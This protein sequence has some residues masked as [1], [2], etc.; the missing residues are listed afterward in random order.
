MGQLNK[1]ACAPRR[2]P[3]LTERARPA[4]SRS[5][6]SHQVGQLVEARVRYVDTSDK[7][8][9]AKLDILPNDIEGLLLL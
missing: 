6:L 2:R 3:P 1:H 5:S 4:P 7:G 8:L 9:F